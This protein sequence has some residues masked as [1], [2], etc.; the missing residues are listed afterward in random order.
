MTFSSLLQLATLLV[1]R[2]DNSPYY[3]GRDINNALQNLTKVTEQ[4]FTWFENNGMK[5]NP[6]KSHLILSHP[7]EKET[8][9]SG[10]LIENSKCEKLLGVLI[11][12]KLTFDQHV[13]LLCNKLVRRSVHL[14]ESHNLWKLAKENSS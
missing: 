13:R 11:D 5:V 6:E 1:P 3:C 7:Y 8:F 2:D 10:E 9:I 4:M 14:H 12:H